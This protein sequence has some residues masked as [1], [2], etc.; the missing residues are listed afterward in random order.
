MLDDALKFDW[1]TPAVRRAFRRGRSN[2]GQISWHADDHQVG[3]IVFSWNAASKIVELRYTI[4]GT[5]RVQRI[6]VVETT[7]RFGGRRCWFWCEFSHRRARIMVL[8][9]DAG[10]FVARAAAGLPYRSQRHRSA[11]TRGLL[12]GERQARA[13]LQRNTVRGLR[14][15]ERQNEQRA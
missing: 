7:P 3:S 4:D 6:K 2:G 8:A 14:R 10:S 12:A 9:P 15:K 13:R 5:P 1:A 11:V